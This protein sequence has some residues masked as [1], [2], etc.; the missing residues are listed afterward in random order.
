[1]SLVWALGLHGLVL[2]SYLCFL[3]LVI[4][5]QLASCS[6]LWLCLP[7]QHGVHLS[8]TLVPNQTLCPEVAFVRVFYHAIE[9]KR[10]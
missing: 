8:G 9:K 1:M 7:C 10:M 3:M 2:A 5:G 4:C 6:C